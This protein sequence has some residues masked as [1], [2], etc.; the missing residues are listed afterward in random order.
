[1]F[2]M[3]SVVIHLCFYLLHFQNFH[4]NNVAVHILTLMWLSVTNVYTQDWNYWSIENI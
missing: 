1:M 4:S 3:V 2:V